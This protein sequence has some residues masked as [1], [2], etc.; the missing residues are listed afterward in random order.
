VLKLKFI[1]LFISYL[2][3]LV[4]SLLNKAVLITLLCVI[5]VGQSVASVTMFYTMT[6]MASSNSTMHSEMNVT[7]S[8]ITSMSH[9]E[10]NSSNEPSQANEQCCTQDCQCLTGSCSTASAFSKFIAYTGIN[11]TSVKIIPLN[12]SPLTQTLPSLYRPPILS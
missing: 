12:Y 1:R 3:L 2:V 11:A 5:L 4:A 10:E 8:A 7:K 9:C 6:G